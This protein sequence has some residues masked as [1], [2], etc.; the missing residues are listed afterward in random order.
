MK[1]IATA[2]AA[3]TVAVLCAGSA[4]AQSVVTQR[5]LISTLQGLGNRTTVLD[6]NKMRQEVLVE[7]KTEN[8]EDNVGRDKYLDYFANLP[9]FDVQILFDFDSDVIK[10]ESY[11][12]LGAMADALHNPVLAGDQFL[13][14]GH[15]DA[16]GA[17]EYN[18]NLSQ[19]RADAIRT[20]L[21][22]FFRVPPER[23]TAFG[24]GEEQLEDPAN[25]YAAINRRVELVN[26]GP[27]PSS[28]L[29]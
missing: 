20:A 29:P 8:T 22:T 19:K 15:T 6:I 1:S 17:R 26:L 5:D 9:N 18:L 10:P 24:L 7:I 27:L 3:A 11:Q 13:I 16:K 23:L 21:V 28:K 14:I 2:I 12:V 25:P 4:N